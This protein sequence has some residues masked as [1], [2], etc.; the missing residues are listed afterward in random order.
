MAD[1]ETPN[2]SAAS[3]KRIPNS[4]TNRSPISEEAY[5]FEQLSYNALGLRPLVLPM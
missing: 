3:V 2:K 5:G 1:V 4:F